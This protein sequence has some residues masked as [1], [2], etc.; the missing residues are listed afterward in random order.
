MTLNGKS[1]GNVSG[2]GYEKNSNPRN[3]SLHMRTNN[4]VYNMWV[5]VWKQCYT[6]AD[7]ITVKAHMLLT[8]SLNDPQGMA[9]MQCNQFL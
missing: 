1:I 4:V 9:A 7:L 3:K 8:H 5:M 2:S 6:R